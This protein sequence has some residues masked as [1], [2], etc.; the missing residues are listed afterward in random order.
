[1]DWNK[2]LDSTQDGLVHEPIVERTLL[3]G[4]AA[5]LVLLATFF[6]VQHDDPIER[7][8]FES[9]SV[10]VAPRI[11]WERGPSGD[12][13]WLTKP[14]VELVISNNLK[15]SQSVS[16][17]FRLT[18]P[19]NCSVMRSVLVSFSGASRKLVLDEGSAVSFSSLL[20]IPAEDTTRVRISISERGCVLSKSDSRE[21]YGQLDLLKLL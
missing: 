15:V 5:I 8:H 3:V 12:F 19:P 1:M 10:E 16:V 4:F 20:E 18:A 11:P 17:S 9:T 13:L 14:T 21:A 2:D 7:P 6:V